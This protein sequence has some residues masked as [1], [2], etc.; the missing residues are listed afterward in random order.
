[1]SRRRLNFFAHSLGESSGLRVKTHWEFLAQLREWGVRVD[2]HSKLCGNLGEAIEYCN[3]WEKK[4]GNLTYDIDGIVIKVNDIAQQKELGF[5]SK[6][7][8]WAVA[9]KFPAH[10]ATTDVLGI[11][12]NVGRTGV[13]TPTV[14]LKPVKC[15]GVIIRNATLHNFDEIKRL[16]IKVGDRVLIERAGEVIPKVVKVVD[17][18][19]KEPFRVP[20]ACPVCLGKVVKEKE[21]DVAYRCINPSC[22]A[23]LERALFH[24]ASRG[25]M[26]IEGMGEVVIAQLVRLRLVKDFADIYELEPQDLKKLELFKEKKIANLLFGIQKSK[27][28]SLSRLIFALGIRHVGEKAAFV[29]A[30]EFKALDKLSSAKKEEL[31]SIYEIGSVMA[32][33]IVDYFSQS[34]TRRLIE[35]LEKAGLNFKE[36]SSQN[37]SVLFDGKNIVFTGELKEFSRQRAEELARSLGANP[38]S[39]VSK[40][41]DFVLV[42]KNPGSKYA[43]ALKLGVRIINEK[44]FKEMIK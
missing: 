40:N 31:D 6:S 12:V 41:T 10:Q 34:S 43:K 19:G 30:R 18:R 39:S 1:M 28:R 9:Y 33:S 26:D 35:R 23:Q 4:R 22:P 8:R 15:A 20:T 38:T 17:S 16:N 3:E 11:N 37:K 32:D 24:F 7:P 14:E 25:A 5:T 36:E 21:E 13:I 29:L 27:R 2:T 42:G 44:K